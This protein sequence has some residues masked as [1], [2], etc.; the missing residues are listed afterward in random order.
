MGSVFFL[1]A[2]NEHSAVADDVA[3]IAVEAVTL[4]S[5]IFGEYNHDVLTIAEF[6]S[7]IGMEFDGIIFLSPTFYNL[8]PGTPESNIHVLYRPMKLPT[9]WFFAAVG[10]DQALEPWLD[11]AMATYTERI[12]YEHFHPQEVNWWQE[13]RIDVFERRVHQPPGVRLSQLRKLPQLGLPEWCP[14]L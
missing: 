5:E 2:F 12:F 13:G 10:N 1:I 8:Y 6:N 7:D 14:V 4:F 9:K 11:E 3:D